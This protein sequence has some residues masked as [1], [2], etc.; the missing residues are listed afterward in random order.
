ML[1][2]N[3]L[4]FIKSLHQKKFRKLE[5]AFFVE[6][7]KNVSE[8]LKSDYEVTHLLYSEKFGEDHF[9]LL[10][11]YVGESYLVSQKV[12]ES[13]GM[14]QTNDSVLAVA[15]TLQNFP[16]NLG[17]DE[18]VIALDN[19][20]DPGNLGTIIRIAD[21]YGIQNLI[22]SSESADFY[23]PKVLQS[24]MGSFTRVKVFYTELL[25]YLDELGKPIFGAFLDGE[26][27]HNV[28]IQK[29]GI[30]LL[31]N[32]SS[33]I[34]PELKHL[35]SN[36]ITIPGFGHAESL[37]VAVATAVICDNFR[38]QLAPHQNSSS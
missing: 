14:Y 25:E 21:W 24:S 11:S 16:P 26:S 2:K 35:V 1:S 18:L 32:E 8:L 9:E 31:G 28:D 13:T 27:I 33:G 12:L 23:N 7:T 15:K 30:I 5:E 29:A 19:V 36:K 20:R 37:N 10:N 3:T 17:K 38:R 4:K 6:G 22:L 34:S